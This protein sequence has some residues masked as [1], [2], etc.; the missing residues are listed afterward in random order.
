M[1]CSEQERPTH[2]QYMLLSMRKK[3]T[4]VFVVV[5]EYTNE[6]WVN[7]SHQKGQNMARRL[8]SDRYRTWFQTK[9]SNFVRKFN[10]FSIKYFASPL[11]T[12]L[13]L[14]EAR[15]IDSTSPKMSGKN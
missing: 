7:V 8:V 14:V 12:K 11:S 15:N 4:K 6:G 5:V 2:S 3:L 10:K 13:S 1:K 9:V